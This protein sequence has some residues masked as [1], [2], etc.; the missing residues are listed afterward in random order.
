MYSTL[1]HLQPGMT[2]HCRITKI[3]IER[4]RVDLTSKSSDLQ[5]KNGEWAPAKDTY[6]DHDTAEK[7][8]KKSDAEKKA[9]QSSSV[10]KVMKE[11]I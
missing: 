2:L 9:T 4:F 1:C 3:D 10:S 11:V 6:Y 7:D 5:D 8:Q